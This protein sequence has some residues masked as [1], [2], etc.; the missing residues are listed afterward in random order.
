MTP[1]QTWC[2]MTAWGK[3]FLPCRL[4]ACRVFLLPKRLSDRAIHLRF[5]YR[6]AA[7]FF[8]ALVCNDMKKL[9]AWV[10]GKDVSGM[11]TVGKQGDTSRAFSRFNFFPPHLGG[12][13]CVAKI[14]PMVIPV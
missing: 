5:P 6:N 2:S 8:V 9:A 11:D 7:S 3:S 10:Q 4:P 14:G 1:W 13:F 12:I